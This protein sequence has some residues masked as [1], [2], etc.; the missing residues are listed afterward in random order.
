MTTE[1]KATEKG[2]NMADQ[3]AAGTESAS[4]VKYGTVEVNGIEVFYREAGPQD[5]PVVL[6]PHGYPSSSFQFR[7]FMPALADRWRL[8][9]PDY[10]RFGYRAT[11]D[12]TR[13]ANTFDGYADLL[14]RFTEAMNL[15]RYTLYLHDYGSQIGLRL[16]MKA[17]ERSPPSSSRT[18]TS[19]KMNSG[20]STRR[21]RTT[22]RTRRRKGAKSSARP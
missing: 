21:S 8:I 13:F 18:A 3:N 2:R 15:T 7:N 16:A 5:A 17:P 6:L 19:T 20:T 10:P 11:P 4:H 12:R 1:N 9:A 14:K 22:G